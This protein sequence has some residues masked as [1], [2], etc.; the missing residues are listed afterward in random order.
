MPHGTMEVM[1]RTPAPLVGRDA[2]LAAVLELTDEGAAAGAVLLSGDAGVGKSRLLTE[3]IAGAQDRGWSTL[4]GYC[5]D[6]G[7]AG[8]AY[9]PISEA[10]GGLARDRPDELQ[11]L[12]E[13][14]PPLARLLPTRRHLVQQTAA[15]DDRVERGPLFDA[16][17]ATIEVMA[18]ST[19][20]LLVLEDL[21]WAD[22]ATRDLLGY[23][24]ARLRGRA[25]IAI[26]GSY[27][28]EE[29]HRR[30]PLRAAVSEWV[31]LP[32]VEHLAL[33]PLSAPDIRRLLGAAGDAI[34]ERQL[35]DV[36]D[37]SGGNAFFAE[38][39]LAS[40]RA[41]GAPMSGALSDLL[42][43]RL[44]RLS[45]EAQLLVRAA[46]VAGTRVTHDLLAAVVEIAEPGLD[47]ALREAVDA[48]LLEPITDVGYSFRHA[49]L[50][51]AVYADL[52]PGERVRLHRAYGQALVRSGGAS[53]AEL[54]RHARGS[55]DLA[56]AFTAGV[57]A[58]DEAMT[59]A[60]AED[61][62]QH[63]ETALELVTHAPASEP[64]AASTVAAKAAD[65]A[66]SGGHWARA[67]AFAKQAV[68][69]LADD[70]D[71]LLRAQLLLDLAKYSMAVDVETGTL[72]A[73]SAALRLVPADP[74]TPLRARVMAWHAHTL[75]TLGR[76]AEADRWGH[77]AVTM[78]ELVDDAIAAAEARTTLAMLRH[79][80]KDPATAIRALQ[81]VR[82]RAR[83]DDHL[84]AELQ[85][86][87]G[88]AM[89]YLGEG[90]LGRA[91]QMLD[92]TAARAVDARFPWVSWAIECRAVAVLT[93]YQLGD[94]DT[95]L[96]LSRTEGESPPPLASA[97]LTATGMPIRVAR[98]DATALAEL[99][100]LRPWSGR[101]TMVA[102]QL[103]AAAE[104]LVH[105]GD[106]EGGLDLLDEVGATMADLQQTELFPGRIRL[107]AL[108]LAALSTTVADL[109]QGGRT[110]VVARARQYWQ[111]AQDVV[112]DDREHDRRQGA[113]GIAWQLRLDAEWCR[114]RWLAGV[115][116]PTLDEHVAA[117]HTSIEAFDYGDRYEQ[118][119]SRARLASVLR[120]SGRVG[121]AVEQA[122]LA[123]A[124]A[125][126]LG[127]ELLLA[128]LRLL[129]TD[130]HREP[131][132]PSGL[133]SLTNRER[134]VLALLEQGR[135][136]RQVSQELYISEKTV[137]VHVTN[138]LAKLGVRS[139]A[140]AAAVARRG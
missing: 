103:L 6:F 48:Y 75:R 10:F 62:M 36:V 120:S 94:W 56:G 64:H 2:E 108:A 38:Q 79:A 23:L 77:E 90:D 32:G 49:L 11:A 116:A 104:L 44:N 102:V 30:H 4:V 34:D 7:D 98:A 137:S 54:A 93:R 133:G 68:A 31:R 39:L 53:A 63:F 131:A 69:D 81:A 26:V 24:L 97:I 92:E 73:T 25:G 15:F 17:L 12:V 113:E 89:L 74:P 123:R 72:D 122:D 112:D 5:T 86:G 37:R 115:D 136:N 22:Q 41:D 139:R 106:V 105:T 111:A 78:A 107:A 16:V 91:L 14:F 109:P 118:A 87:Y 52:L 57:R 50:A 66:S 20:V 40:T 71:P 42:L 47:D 21:H 99:A 121:E 59:V 132:G 140:E 83:Q 85:S 60:A 51:E 127:A 84:T 9:L 67:L 80:R 61:A 88:I 100:R 124:V 117:W 55:H 82:Q 58:G 29:L 125:R 35:S 96:Q 8:V 110:G 19:G 76:E 119:R 28:A 13:R 95:G 129:G 65:A 33:T 134:E 130:R 46:A 138:L 3:I 70:A 1:P 101:D 27:R 114:L 18:E 126:E 45:P 135:T 128:E 43:V